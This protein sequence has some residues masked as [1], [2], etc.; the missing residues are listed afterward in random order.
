[1][2]DMRTLMEGFKKGLNESDRIRDIEGE[3]VLLANNGNDETEI[4]LAIQNK[5][6]NLSRSEDNA[7]EDM[8]DSHLDE[9]SND[10]PRSINDRT[11][12]CKNCGESVPWQAGLE[13]TCVSCGKP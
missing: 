11:R 13:D 2:K 8:I 6:G 10:K 1:M 9:G 12:K 7:M 4:R 3:V 5:F